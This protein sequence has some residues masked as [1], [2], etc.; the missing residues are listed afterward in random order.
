MVNMNAR[1]FY[2]QTETGGDPALITISGFAMAATPDTPIGPLLRPG[3]VKAKMSQFP[4][5][6]KVSCGA[7][8]GTQM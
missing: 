4:G 5:I 6:I 1:A 7:I 2:V 3:N 8:K